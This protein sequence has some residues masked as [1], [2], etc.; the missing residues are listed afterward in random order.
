VHLITHWQ[1][2]L[3]IGSRAL[4]KPMIPQLMILIATLVFELGFLGVV[5]LHDR[6]LAPWPGGAD[7]GAV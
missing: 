1:N 7:P 5:G 3:F 4:F 6:L 2:V